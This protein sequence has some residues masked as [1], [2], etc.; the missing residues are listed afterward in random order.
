MCQDVGTPAQRPCECPEQRGVR[1]TVIDLLLDR[2][3]GS[4]QARGKLLRIAAG[5]DQFVVARRGQEGRELRGG[6]MPHWLRFRR[7]VRMV[8]YRSHVGIDDR[9]EVIRAGEAAPT[10]EFA[11]AAP[12]LAEPAPIERQH[13]GVV[14]ARAVADHEHPSRVA[15]PAP[16]VRHRMVERGRAV[17]QEDRVAYFRVEPI[18]GNH[19]QDAL[20]G[21][22]LADKAILRALATIPG[23]AVEKDDDRI[24]LRRRSFERPVEIGA[25]ARV[26]AI[27]QP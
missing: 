14:C 1:D 21:E 3:A 18:V 25:L 27:A 9:D 6:R 11:R 5:I 4:A 16:E 24:A 23:A 20:R 8:E 10:G 13:R 15:P 19:G 22:R 2:R 26:L 17:V 12:E 7:R